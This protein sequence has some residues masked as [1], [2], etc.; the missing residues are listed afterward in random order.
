MGPV[1]VRNV[2]LQTNNAVFKGKMK[3]VIQ[4]IS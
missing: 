1:I 3:K 4:K 2:M